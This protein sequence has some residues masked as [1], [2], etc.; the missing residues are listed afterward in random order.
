[1]NYDASN[2][3]GSGTEYHDE[4]S[5]SMMLDNSVLNFSTTTFDF[6]IYMEILQLKE[7]IMY[8]FFEVA[9]LQVKLVQGVDIKKFVAVGWNKIKALLF[10]RTRFLHSLRSTSS[11][12][13]GQLEKLVEVFRVIAPSTY[14]DDYESLKA[15]HYFEKNLREYNTDINRHVVQMSMLRVDIEIDWLKDRLRMA[16][17]YV[18]SGW[19]AHYKMEY[20][21]IEYIIKTE[22]NTWYN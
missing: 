22:I 9:L 20:I 5:E 8:D 14:L 6:N 13:H 19:L 21:F 10:T 2:S 7:L 11:N 15:K 16:M 3:S 18:W 17:P 12:H 1:M 4:L